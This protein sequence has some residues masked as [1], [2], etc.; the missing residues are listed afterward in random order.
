MAKIFYFITIVSIIGWV[1][2][3]LLIASVV[4]EKESHLSLV[5]RIYQELKIVKKEL[6][7]IKNNS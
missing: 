5:Q 2:M 1:W 4:K 6:E 7:D 3:L